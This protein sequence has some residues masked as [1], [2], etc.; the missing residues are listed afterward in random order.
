MDNYWMAR[1]SDGRWLGPVVGDH[2][3]RALIDTDVTADSD[4]PDRLHSLW[5][6]VPNSRYRDLTVRKPAADRLAATAE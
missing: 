5:R 2:A 6:V 3:V 4:G 1:T